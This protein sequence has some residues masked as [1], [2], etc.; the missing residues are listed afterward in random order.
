MAPRGPKTLPTNLKVVTGTVR[1]HRLNPDEPRPEPVAPDAPDH[2][3]DVARAEWDRIVTE[4]TA[5]GLLTRLDRGSLAAYCQAWGRWR[6][7]EEALAR[8]AGRDSATEGLMIRTK[9]GNFIQNPLVGTANKAMADMLRYAAEFG[10]TPSARSRIRTS[11]HEI[12]PD[13][14]AAEF[15]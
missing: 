15:F 6:T 3:T 7:A 1:P 5:L 8:M 14:P 9:S 2:L 12:G 10:M 11:G 4:L 13:D